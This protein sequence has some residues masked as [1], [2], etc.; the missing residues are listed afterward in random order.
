MNHIRKEAESKSIPFCHDILFRVS[1]P[2]YKWSAIY[3][4]TF[5][6]WFGSK[7]R[8]IFSE[9]DMIKELMVNNNDS[10][11][12]DAFN[13]LSKQLFGQGLVGLQ[14]NKWAIHRKITSQAFTMERV[15]AW[16]PEIVAS[17]SK[18]LNRWEEKRG[19]RDEF[20]IEVHKVLHNLS[21]DI[22]SRTA[23]GSSF[24][25]G[26]RI[27]E[28]QEQQTTL[29][30]QAMRSVYI[31]GLRFLPTNRNRMMWKLEKQIRDS[32]RMLIA[33]NSKIRENSSNLLSLLMSVNF[34]N[35]KDNQGLGVEEVIDECK[36]FYF[37][38]KE[39]TANLLTWA[40]LLLAYHQEW[41]SMARKEVFRVSKN[42][43]LP[44]AEN[45]ND[46]KI[47][48]SILNETLRLYPPVVMLMR[49][50]SKNIKL[51]NLD[52]PANTQFNLPIAAV[53]HDPSIWG[54][55]ANEFNPQRFAEPRKHLA[56]YFPFGLGPRI[57]VGQNL[58]V[59]ESKLILAMILQQFSFAI[60]P[61][62][63]HAPILSWTLEPQYGAHLIFRRIST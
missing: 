24:E 29:T 54:E 6:F 19:G 7:P 11:F 3:G 42:N 37:A 2:Y 39:T 21:A 22:I 45:L 49:Q 62:Y 53:H 28:L 55:D 61:S 15:K 20:E 51:G 12:K 16:V 25:E 50:T 46:F 41:Q 57:C 31:P 38:G 26:K 1:P 32:V 56:S 27:F 35:D 59:V 9:P 34:N 14:G 23:F 58:A 36:T 4:K 47:V 43:E 8:L 48:G 30:L 33:K 60:S 5:L 13:P 17:T 63:V 18:E 10:V 40:L 52:V 44:D